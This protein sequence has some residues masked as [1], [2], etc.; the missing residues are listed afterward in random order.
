MRIVPIYDRVLVLPKPADKESEGGIILPEMRKEK[1]ME[2]TVIAVGD[3]HVQMHT[4]EMRP[5]RVIVGDKI[6][7]NKYAGVEIVLD[8][9]EY[10]ML[11]EEDILAI[12]D[13]SAPMQTLLE[14]DAP[15]A[16]K[17]KPK[18][19]CKPKSKC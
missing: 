5:T 2:G 4:Q 15:M 6:I 19:A 13:K 7:F 18:T 3:G 1:P 16:K 8:K 17:C 12:M 14:G 10:V 11:R 9:I